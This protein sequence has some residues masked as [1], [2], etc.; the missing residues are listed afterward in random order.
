ME[1]LY[2]G[3]NQKD[4]RT[5]FEQA[6][7]NITEIGHG[8]FGTVHAATYL[9]TGKQYAIKKAH[10]LYCGDK[11]RKSALHEVKIQELLPH[12]PNIVSFFKAWEECDRLYIQLELC[13][14]YSL[15]DIKA[16]PSC[17]NSD[18][19]WIWFEDMTKAV[20]F[21]HDHQII[22]LDVKPDNIFLASNGHC[23]LGDF[24]L[25]L[26]LNKDSLKDFE[27]GDSRYLAPEI[28]NNP[29]TK[30]ADIYSLGMSFLHMSIN[31]EISPKSKEYKEICEKLGNAVSVVHQKYF[32]RVK[33]EYFL[34]LISTLINI[35]PFARPKANELLRSIQSNQKPKLGL[36][37]DKKTKKIHF[38]FAVIVFIFSFF[39]AY[40]NVK[41]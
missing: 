24:G 29:P 36:I 12:H 31:D 30:A 9:G 10:N 20:K 13:G 32:T 38:H 4:P 17:V 5:Y 22:H 2:A 11:N 14:K 33:D 21:L 3:Y 37:F 8:S 7:V 16:C 40:S 39:S 26:D 28:L 18:S 15:S 41:F 6:F 23:K 1:K 25:A 34:K 19:L 35:D 27:D